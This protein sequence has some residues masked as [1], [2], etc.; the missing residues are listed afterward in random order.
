MKPL[1][2]TVLRNHFQTSYS[3]H[4][5][6]LSEKITIANSIIQNILYHRKSVY[7]MYIDAVLIDSSVLIEITKHTVFLNLFLHLTYYVGV[8]KTFTV[9]IFL[10]ENVRK[11]YQPTS[12]GCM[13]P[14]KPKPGVITSTSKFLPFTEREFPSRATVCRS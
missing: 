2:I 14:V 3:L 11:C 9:Y 6:C 8:F 4:Y 5:F 12:S 10:R 13:Y 7:I 1:D